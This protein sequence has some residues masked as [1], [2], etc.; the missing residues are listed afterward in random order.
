[1][2]AT[3]G[4][5]IALGNPFDVNANVPSDSRQTQATIAARNAIVWKYD[6]L[7]CYVE[8]EKTSYIFILGYAS[9]S[10]LDN[11]NWAPM[12][13]SEPNI[14]AAG[15][16]TKVTVNTKGR[17]IGGDNISVTDVGG[18]ID[19]GTGRINQLLMP[20]ISIVD[21]FVRN[22]QA[23]MLALD[24]QQG[25]I[26]VRTDI[27]KS[28]IL[29]TDDPTQVGNWQELL[30]TSGTI[31]S[32]SL[33]MPTPEFNVSNPTITSAGTFGVSWK[34]QTAR[35]VLA[36]PT[37][38]TGVPSFR[39]LGID[40]VTGLPLTIYDINY[41][42]GN[43]ANLVG[44]N[45]FGGNQF[46]NNGFLQ[47]ISDEG[48]GIL[49]P[50]E[51]ILGNYEG[52]P[53]QIT[54]GVTTIV[55]N[56]PMGAI[57]IGLPIDN[58]V[59]ALTSQIPT[60]YVTTNTPQS[61]LVGTKQWG[62][63]H[64][65]DVGS[66]ST[67][68][69]LLNNTQLS[70]STPGNTYSGYLRGDGMEF[71]GPGGNY[72]LN[73]NNNALT[74]KAGNYGVG[75]NRYTR[76]YAQAISADNN[77]YLPTDSGT[78]ALT[79]QI[80]ALNG[81]Y[82]PLENQRLSTSNIPTFQ[83]LRIN[84]GST[85]Y[86]K[87]LIFQHNGL[88]RWNFYSDGAESGSDSGS[89]L[90]LAS[91]YDDAN[92]KANIFLINRATGILNFSSRPT[93]AGNGIVSNDGG[94]YNINISGRAARWSN[95]HADFSSE[96]TTLDYFI[97]W[98]DDGRGGS[99]FGKDKAKAALNLNDG[100][101]LNNSISGSAAKWANIE[102]GGVTT[103]TAN[104]DYLYSYNSATSTAYIS[105][106]ATIKSALATSLQDV[107]DVSYVTTNPIA[108]QRGVGNSVLFVGPEAFAFGGTSDDGLAFVYGAN[109]YHIATNSAKR[110]TVD[111]NGN[112]GIGT[113]SPTA[114]LDVNG[115]TF[116]GSY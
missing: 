83:G 25:D 100:S 1:M 59:L 80:T 82:Q 6:G 37:D 71:R 32:V 96:G 86:Y 48:I 115:N 21:T 97:G 114:M 79:S 31:T 40:D 112:I 27:N 67:G 50:S 74:F 12:S 46:V 101:T 90:Y 33:S 105:P 14:V 13:A 34:T 113:T 54:L 28:F 93:I 35:T 44:G 53:P 16:Y 7:E 52:I 2:A 26:C 88:H 102:H 63:E 45:N 73:I 24:A 92:Y 108:F 20:A 57:E 61:G 81:V 65:W 107:T 94:T 84:N 110:F 64:R 77:L 43:K 75:V 47:V 98:Q 58:G 15:T 69:N 42:L 36:G 72:S 39:V 95:L 5:G 23:A 87:D 11:N 9:N 68:I 62:A 76:L 22:S 10:L 85:N 3:I 8:S 91:Y 41:T 17:V 116:V 104:I 49:R 55:G 18:L 70:F 29:T 60:N 111:E 103:N 19:M 51:L 89:N 78:L 106:K 99:Y 30:S 66:G 38:S 56:T 109:K 4:N